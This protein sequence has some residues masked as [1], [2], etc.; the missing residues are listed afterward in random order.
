M[1][2]FHGKVVGP[3]VD[4]RRVAS[5]RLLEPPFAYKYDRVWLKRKQILVFRLGF[6]LLVVD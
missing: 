2:R 6:S 3:R 5:S 4:L 1:P